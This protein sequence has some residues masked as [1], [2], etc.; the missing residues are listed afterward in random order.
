ML[1]CW[2]VMIP[3]SPLQYR[4]NCGHHHIPL[5]LCCAAELLCHRPCYSWIFMP[6]IWPSCNFMCN[7]IYTFIA[8]VPF[9]YDV[10]LWPSPYWQ[11]NIWLLFFLNIGPEYSVP[12][13][14][15]NSDCPDHQG[16]VYLHSTQ[17][18]HGNTVDFGAWQFLI[19]WTLSLCIQLGILFE[20]LWENLSILI[21]FCTDV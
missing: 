19:Y 12:V 15:Q 11:C 4:T 14:N 21:G 1:C 7:A 13:G 18:D 5:C 17:S 8:E 10:Q 20:I 9:I 16:A 6:P 3:W 2:T